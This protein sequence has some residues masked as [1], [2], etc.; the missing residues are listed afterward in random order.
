[1]TKV[2]AVALLSF[3]ILALSATDAGAADRVQPG[4]WETALRVKSGKP[5][6]TKS[7]ITAAESRLMN[8]DLPTMRKYLE[9]STAKNTQG[10]CAFKKVELNG[11]RVVVTLVCGKSE[12]VGTTTYH[13]DHYESSSSGGV[14][15]VGKRLG[16]C[17]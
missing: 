15:I 9:D 12:T 8:G 13:G 17:P 14:A 4:Q 7:C 16:A 11:N 2:F 3:T 10:R 6:I 1:M 5:M